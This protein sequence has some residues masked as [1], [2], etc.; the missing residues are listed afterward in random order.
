MVTPCDVKMA[1]IDV[2][3]IDRSIW[4]TFGRS[5]VPFVIDYR[6]PP[7][8]Y[9][10]PQIYYRNR[11]PLFYFR[12]PLFYYRN[13]LFYYRNPLFYYRN[14]L[15]YYRNPLFYYR[16]P[17]IY[18][19]NPLFYYRNPLF[20]YRNPLF[21]NC[22][23]DRPGSKNTDFLIPLKNTVI[24]HLS[25]GICKSMLDIWKWTHLSQKI[26]FFKNI[27][28][29]LGFFSFLSKYSQTIGRPPFPPFKDGFPK[30]EEAPTLN[31]WTG[32]RGGRTFWSS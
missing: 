19:R 1:A 8:Y 25:H 28:N 11:N 6:N 7:I 13:P 22:L 23:Y 20:Y 24:P 16:N 17:Q 29:P 10:N 27:E 2:L 30:N 15:F 31:L 12:N 5:R 18:Y 9:R 26:R 21:W 14:P 3:H 32:G 4:T